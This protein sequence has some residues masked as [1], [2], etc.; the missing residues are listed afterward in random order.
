MG[1][2]RTSSIIYRTYINLILTK[3]CH[4]TNSIDFN[5]QQASH[6]TLLLMQWKT[7]Q[8]TNF[9]CQSDTWNVSETLIWDQIVTGVSDKDFRK[10]ALKEEWTLQ[11]LEDHGRRTEA[12]AL[13]AAALTHNSYVK[14]SKIAGKYSKKY[15]NKENLYASKKD[16]QS[17][18]HTKGSF[19]CFC[20]GR[21]CCNQDYCPAKRLICHLC[22]GK[23]HWA[24]SI[25]CP[26]IEN[27]GWK[28]NNKHSKDCAKTWYVD[29]ASTSTDESQKQIQSRQTQQKAVT[30]I[31]RQIK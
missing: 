20:C 28:S 29:E 2:L 21:H 12:A 17:E 16:N 7:E 6:L 1:H 15:W 19:M 18:S 31:R 13:G 9:K 26:G 24:G 8:K 4:I 22:K 27:L 11:Q 14:V 30:T 25:M 3:P 5:N 23:G 10:K